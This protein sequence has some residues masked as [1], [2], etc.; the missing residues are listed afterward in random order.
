MSTIDI[1]EYQPENKS[2][3][4]ELILDIQRNE[5]QIPITREEQ[6]DL[7]NIPEFYQSGSGN[8]WVASCEGRVIGSIALVDIGNKQVAL[9]KLFVKPAYRGSNYN[10]AKLLLAELINWAAT[11]EVTEIF[12]GTT[13]KFLAAHRFYEKNGFAEITKESLPPA[14]P[15]MKVDTKF[16]YYKM[17]K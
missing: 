6:P 12:L 16:Y 17:N 4:I 14:F 7:C 8:F 2:E 1:R 5:F 13:A 9:R 11:Q 10:T 3:I 15:V